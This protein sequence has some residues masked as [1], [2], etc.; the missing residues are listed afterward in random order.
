MRVF[1]PLLK[2]CVPSRTQISR[3]PADSLFLRSIPDTELPPKCSSTCRDLGYVPGFAHLFLLRSDDV[4][5][6]LMPLSDR[7]DA[8]EM[9]GRVK[10][11]AYL[12]NVG[13]FSVPAEMVPAFFSMADRLANFIPDLRFWDD[14][15]R[16]LSQ[17]QRDS[18]LKGPL[19]QIWRTDTEMDK[20]VVV[21]YQFCLEK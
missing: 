4:V 6:I 7:R 13:H 1:L 12:G 20:P 21:I 5:H 18:S 11:I 10:S 8:G 14:V 15:M 9:L 19:T 16:Q 3:V 17:Q 2:V